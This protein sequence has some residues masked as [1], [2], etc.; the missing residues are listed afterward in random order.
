M[1]TTKAL[2]TVLTVGLLAGCGPS[3]RYRHDL[4]EA[5]LQRPT[6]VQHVTGTAEEVDFRDTTMCKDDRAAWQ[7][8]VDAA[9]ANLGDAEVAAAPACIAD[10]HVPEEAL[11]FIDLDPADPNVTAKALRSGYSARS[12]VGTPCAKQVCAWLALGH[13]TTALC[14]VKD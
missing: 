3:Y 13:H 11:R 6:C 2:L 12:Y 1:Y 7:Q 5:S 9:Q 10:W 14:P 4:R 8:R